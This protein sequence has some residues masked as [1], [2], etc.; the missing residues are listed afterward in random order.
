MTEQRLLVIDIEP[1]SSSSTPVEKKTAKPFWTCSDNTF[2]F[3]FLP[4]NS[5]AFQG[6][7]TPLDRTEP[8]T[9]QISFIQQTSPFAFNFQIPPVPPQ[10]EDMDITQTPDA[11]SP[12]SEQCTKK[13]NPPQ[14]SAASKSKKKKKKSG[15]K[16]PSDSAEAQQ[17]PSSTEGREGSEETEL[18]AEEQLNRQLDWCIEQ[19]E[20]GLKSQ[21]G[22]P[23]QK[24]EA[25][26]ALKTLRSSK[27]P[28][29]KKRQVMRAMTG[30]YR[31]KMEE[32]KM[33]QFKLIQSEMASAQVK[34]VSESPKKSVFHRKAEVKTETSENKAGNSHL[35][36]TTQE[37]TEGFV[38]T[39]SNEEFRF[40]FL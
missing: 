31:T 38:F 33:K 5:P 28:L 15:K 24:E 10:E 36:T 40:N 7:P 20:L 9:S 1:K 17:E 4:D 12:S 32:E 14:T 29:V 22:T 39:P 19:L 16:Q 23:K 21:K 18:S 11:T 30:D 27:A 34:A 8:T 3:N 35:K 13:E 25:S 6:T 37:G 26:R 2:R